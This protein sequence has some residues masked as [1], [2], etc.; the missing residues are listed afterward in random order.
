MKFFSLVFGLT[1]I[2]FAPDT[3]AQ[4]RMGSGPDF[5]DGV[6][7]CSQPP[8]KNYV[9]P[10]G[11]QWATRWGAIAIDPNAP[12]GGVGVSSD[13]K[14]RRAAEKMA[15]RLCRSSGGGKTCRIQT[16]YDNQCGVIAW[17]DRYYSTANGAT[18]DE[19]ARL[20]LDECAKETSGCRVFYSNCSY[21]VRIR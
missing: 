21:P 19:A 6:P 16:S 13:S 15:V 3:A 17:G 10:S 8:P 20:A 18:V 7:Y 4:C 11:P 12:R 5:G 1:L 2:A 14:S 9:E